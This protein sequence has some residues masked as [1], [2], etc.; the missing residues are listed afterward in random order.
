LSTGKEGVS[1]GGQWR[2]IVTSWIEL[3]GGG[4]EGYLRVGMLEEASVRR[5]ALRRVCV[6]T[7][8]VNQLVGPE[9]RGGCLFK[10]FL[11]RLELELRLQPLL[12]SHRVLQIYSAILHAPASGLGGDSL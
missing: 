4:K 5:C 9:G 7:L 6:E 11:T 3:G 12:A 10:L 2:G 1:A 8:K